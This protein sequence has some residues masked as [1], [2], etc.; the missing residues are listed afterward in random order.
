MN[1]KLTFSQ[2]SFYRDKFLDTYYKI[3]YAYIHRESISTRVKYVSVEQA[4][5]E[6]NI[7]PRARV[8]VVLL[9]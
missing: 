8:N 2:I 4:R 9:S 1:K 7:A 3:D 6:V 5:D